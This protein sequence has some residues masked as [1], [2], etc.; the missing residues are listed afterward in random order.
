MG[1]KPKGAQLSAHIDWSL[2]NQDPPCGK[3]K[4][5]A[6]DACMRAQ[7]FKLVGSTCST[8]H[9]PRVHWVC[10]WDYKLHGW[11]LGVHWRKVPRVEEFCTA[12]KRRFVLRLLWHFDM[13]VDKQ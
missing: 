7:E 3:C 6:E 12:Y 11:Q 10:G 9:L 1:S 4:W 8:D 13:W 5:C 2:C